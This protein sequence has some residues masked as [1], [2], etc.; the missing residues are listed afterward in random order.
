MNTEKTKEIIYIETSH[1]LPHPRQ[2]EIYKDKELEEE[3][4]QSIETRSILQPLLVSNS[5]CIQQIAEG[6]YTVIAGHRRLKAAIQLELDTVPCIIKNYENAD[7][8]WAD[9]ILSNLHRKKN[10]VEI[11]KEMKALKKVLKHFGYLKQIDGLKQNKDKDLLKSALN[12]DGDN[13]LVPSAQSVDDIYYSDE[14]A[15]IVGK[16]DE[17]GWDTAEIIAHEFNI[18]VKRMDKIIAVLDDEYQTN[19]M[20]RLYD[21]GMSIKRGE[22]LYD[23]WQEVRAKFEAGIISLDAA[24]KQVLALKKEAKPSSTSASLVNKNMHKLAGNHKSSTSVSLVPNLIYA[25][26]KLE[27]FEVIY[28]DYNS[29][30]TDNVAGYSYGIISKSNEIYFKTNECVY[31][32]NW[33]V[34]TSLVK[35][36]IAVL[37]K[38]EAL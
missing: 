20:T 30:L 2:C 35:S 32:I 31:I 19:A 11:S 24:Y 6:Y 22:Q 28:S 18:P 3:F 26:F 12:N 36:E 7:D 33:A 27:E 13:P 21:E 15:K 29:I 17:R 25:S 1:L 16:M 14:I 9:V 23:D 8:A 4:L 37:N 34:L 38:E 10:D 5:N